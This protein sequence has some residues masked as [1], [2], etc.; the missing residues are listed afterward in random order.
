MTRLEAQGRVEEAM[1]SYREAL[2]LDPRE[3][4]ARGRLEALVAAM[5]IKVCWLLAEKAAAANLFL[6]SSSLPPCF[7]VGPASGRL[8]LSHCTVRVSGASLV[9]LKHSCIHTLLHCMLLMSTHSYHTFGLHD[10]CSV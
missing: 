7:T 5:E 6:L 4:T 1:E 10:L 8:L 3:E 2:E 9:S